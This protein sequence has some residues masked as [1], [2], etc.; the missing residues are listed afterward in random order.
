MLKFLGFGTSILKWIKTFNNDIKAT[1]VQCGITSEF[2]DIE[3][4]CR[5]GDPILSYEFILC[6]QILYLMIT[7]NDQTKRYQ[8]RKQTYE[9]NTVC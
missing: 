5:Q 7:C 1:I 3:R 9:T 8:N 2:L 6:A 4:G